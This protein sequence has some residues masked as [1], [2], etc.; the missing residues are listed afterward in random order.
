MRS[1]PMNMNN[2]PEFAVLISTCDAFSD[3]W[4]PAMALYRKNWAD[5]PAPILL[6]TDRG[7]DRRFPGVE[8][9]CAGAGAEMTERL[10]RAMEQVTAPYVLLTLDDY[11]LTR[12]ISTEKIRQALSFMEDEG[13]D[14]V[15]MV[16]ASGHYLR[17][18]GA[19]EFPRHRGFY[20]RCIDTG[21]YKVSLVPG[22]WRVSFLRATLEGPPRTA[23]AYEVSLTETARAL[24][25]KC[26]ISNHDEF[27]YLD[28]I[29]KGRLLHRARRWFVKNGVPLLDREIVPL[30]TECS[31]AV[32]TFLRHWLPQDLFRRLKA[33]MSRRG[34]SFFS[35]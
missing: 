30:K 15:R 32:R 23:W 21:S 33:A 22:L 7:T 19:S 11:F 12:P 25:A 14:Y 6:V 28:V 17:R 27:P 24:N 16:P 4:D 8:T 3:L 13:V 31:L 18:E 1:K 20:L 26:A 10:R 35:D 34:H 9:V 29:R 2:H 5:C